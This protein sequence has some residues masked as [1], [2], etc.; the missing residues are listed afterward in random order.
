MKEMDRKTLQ[1]YLHNAILLETDIATQEHIRK[2]YNSNAES[3]KPQFLPRP[4]PEKPTMTYTTTTTQDDSLSFFAWGFGLLFFSFIYLIAGGGFLLLPL[5]GGAGLILLGFSRKSDEKKARENE[6]SEYEYALES[7]HKKRE[8]IERNNNFGRQQ[9]NRDLD[10][11]SQSNS[12]NLALIDSKI[13]ESKA[14]LE[15]FYSL[16]VIFPKYRNLPALTRIY[17]Y[18]ITERCDSLTGAHGAYNLYEDEIRADIIIGQL[19]IVIQKLEQIKQNQYLLYQQVKQIQQTTSGIES[20]LRQLKGYTVQ[21][22]SLTALNTYYAALNERNSRIL[23]YHH[24]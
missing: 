19:S 18:F 15:K 14:A 22:A 3:R 4:L 6:E 11:W 13:E 12:Q 24:L 10:S 2:S 17:E 8:I 20:E 7:Y 16:D 5:I 23:M 21:I 9:Y 1:E